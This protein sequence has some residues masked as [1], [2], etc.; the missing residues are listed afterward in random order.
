[1]CDKCAKESPPPQPV[2]IVPPEECSRCRT[3]WKVRMA[4]ASW[5][6]YI[7][8][9]TITV[10]FLYDW[11]KGTMGIPV[12]VCNFAWIM[13]FALMFWSLTSSFGKYVARKSGMLN[14]DEGAE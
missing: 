2:E 7:L 4:E 9:M 10:L 1:M 14:R 6:I 13:A 11:T 8:S 12:S 5:L 3:K